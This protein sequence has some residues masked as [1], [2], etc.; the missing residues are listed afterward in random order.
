MSLE[1]RIVSLDE[2]DTINR[3]SVGDIVSLVVQAAGGGLSATANTPVS[4]NCL[5][6][7][8]PPGL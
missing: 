5:V 8:V 3:L 4:D 6:E 1:F 7:I 2:A